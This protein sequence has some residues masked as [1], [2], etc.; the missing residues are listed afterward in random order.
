MDAKDQVLDPNVK[1]IV[2]AMADDPALDTPAK[3]R[4]VIPG[5]IDYLT[6]AG[7]CYTSGLFSAAMRHLRPDVM[8]FSHPKVGEMVQ[9]LFFNGQ[10]PPYMV[11]D[12]TGNLVPM[13]P[14]QVS[15][16]TEG[17]F[18][19]RTPAG[20][21]VF[22]YGPDRTACEQYAF[23]VF[24]PKPGE[25]MADAPTPAVPQ[26]QQAA[27][28]KTG[29]TKT[30]VAI[31][32]QRLALDKIEATV[33]PD[34]RLCIPRAAFEMAVHLGGAPLRGGDPVFVKIGP[35][36]ITVTLAPS[37]DVDEKSYDLSTEKGRIAITA[38]PPTAPFTPKTSFPVTVTAGL[39]TVN[40]G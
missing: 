30:A 19:T 14:M 34:G 36:E 29:R 20:I 39:V 13:P 31:M 35:K 23:E 7:Q 18:P 32:G 16:I 15:R 9:D 40:I 11:D 17:L 2:D 37:G 25:S 8:V 12:G 26:T 33:W 21:A 27:T 3:W 4:A 24:I 28:D 6:K 38:K 1:V 22:V 10:L 5:V